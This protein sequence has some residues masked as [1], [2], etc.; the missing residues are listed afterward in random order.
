M[1]KPNGK[2]GAKNHSN[3][4]K[5]ENDGST[6]DSTA[7]S[8]VSCDLISNSSLLYDNDFDVAANFEMLQKRFDQKI[9]LLQ[10]HF[11]AKVNALHEVI[12]DKDV[13]IGKLNNQIGELKQCCDFLTNETS[14]LGGKVKANE[15]SLT[16]S[17]K[18]YDELVNKNSDLEDRSRR[19]NAVFFNIPETAEENCESIISNLLKSRGFFER[20][21]SLEL[22]RVHRLGKKRP[23]NDSRPRPIIARF[24]FYKDKDNV[25]KNGKLFKDSNVIVREDYSKLTS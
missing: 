19:N 14:E 20:D 17:S 13:T 16:S 7:S 15:I 1:T 10:T 23:S 18:H 8:V 4:A 21:S 9:L 11:E 3:V 6:S 5:K 2:K 12:R 22:D 25:I 24:C